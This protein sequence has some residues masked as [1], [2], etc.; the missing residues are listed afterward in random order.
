MNKMADFKIPGGKECR[1]FIVAPLMWESGAHLYGVYFAVGTLLLGA[2]IFVETV[3]DWEMLS[4]SAI[5]IF[6]SVF[7]VFGILSF[8]VGFLNYRYRNLDIIEKKFLRDFTGKY[9]EKSKVEASYWMD[10]KY[11]GTDCDYLMLGVVVHKGLSLYEVE[12]YIRGDLVNEIIPI[13]APLDWK[14][15]NLEDVKNRLTVISESAIGKRKDAFVFAKYLILYHPEE[16]KEAFI[17]QPVYSIKFVEKVLEEVL[18]PQE[19]FKEGIV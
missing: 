15:I 1:E 18:T 10:S 6:T 16:F 5:S 11:N 19:A 7:L 8:V 13:K 4:P 12:V 2:F 14:K 3:S 17:K 9:A